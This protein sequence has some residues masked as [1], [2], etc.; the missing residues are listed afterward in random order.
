MKEVIDGEEVREG[1]DE[2]DIFSELA[3]NKHLPNFDINGYPL[4]E[5]VDDG[6]NS[7]RIRDEV[8]NNYMVQ[9]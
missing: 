5:E 9:A 7:P 3:E 4:L 1:A 6:M 2:A 8:W